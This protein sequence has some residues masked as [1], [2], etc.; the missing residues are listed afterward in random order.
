MA[1]ANINSYQPSCYSSTTPVAS[2]VESLSLSL[3]TPPSRSLS[4]CGY[5]F[6]VKKNASSPKNSYPSFLFVMFS[7][8]IIVASV[9]LWAMSG[10]DIAYYNEHKTYSC[11]VTSISIGERT[12]CGVGKGLHP[13]IIITYTGDATRDDST[14]GEWVSPLP[15]IL[16][17][18]CDPSD[19]KCMYSHT[20]NVYDCSVSTGGT[21]SFSTYSLNVALLYAAI[22]VSCIGV[23]VVLW[24]IRYIFFT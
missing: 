12:L 17:E 1:T 11:N 15:F 2:D 24:W 9:T 8:L 5:S 22:I 19:F 3:S 6:S 10:V 21:W 18:E 7:C 23:C 13:C 20:L 16:L 4:C 14:R